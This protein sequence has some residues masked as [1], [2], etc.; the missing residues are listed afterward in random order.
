MDNAK[1]AAMKFVALLS[2]KVNTS[3]GWNL[4]KTVTL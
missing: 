3:A 1:H 4:P 2:P